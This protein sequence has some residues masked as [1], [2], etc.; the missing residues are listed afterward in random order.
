MRDV[1]FEDYYRMNYV[2]MPDYCKKANA[3]CYTVTKPQ[4]R[5]YCQSIVLKNQK[6]GKIGRAHV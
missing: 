1:E 2:G 6:D 3:I 4:K 5:S